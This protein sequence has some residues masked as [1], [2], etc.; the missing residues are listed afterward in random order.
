MLF[1]SGLG[2]VKHNVTPP[3]KLFKE[4][5]R[6]F[7]NILGEKGDLTTHQRNAFH[8]SAVN[9]GKDFLLTY[10][11]PS[12]EINNRL[13]AQRY[14]QVQE[15]QRLIPIVKTIILCGR[16]NIPLRGHRD[17]GGVNL[18]LTEE[19]GPVHNDGNFKE[20]LKCRI[21]AGDE[22]LRKHLESANS[23]A[24]YISKTTQNK[25]I[26]CCK[27]VNVF[28]IKG[29]ICLHLPCTFEIVNM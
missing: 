19:S 27:G 10:N 14:A 24:A 29:F 18:N 12:L 28:F 1:L 11:D 9:N 3:K 21:D 17:D 2:N 22:V 23:N 13:V 15:K 4:P 5:L 8:V 25:I 6:K 7:D 16:Q 20:L 26:D